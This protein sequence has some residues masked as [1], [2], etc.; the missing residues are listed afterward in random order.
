MQW[1]ERC[2]C[3]CVWL[4]CSMLLLI[5]QL[6]QN[7]N[8]FVTCSN[9]WRQNTTLLIFPVREIRCYPSIEC[10]TFDMLSR[11]NI[12]EHQFTRIMLKTWKSE[13][14]SLILFYNSIGLLHAF[15]GAFAVWGYSSSGLRMHRLPRA[16]LWLRTQRPLGFETWEFPGDVFCGKN[17]LPG[18]D[19]LQMTP[20]LWGF[21]I[22]MNFVNLLVEMSGK[23]GVTQR[24]RIWVVCW[25][26][27]WYSTSPCLFLSELKG[28]SHSWIVPWYHKTPIQAKK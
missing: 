14:A 24:C 26:T 12:I 22:F 23:R 17:H 28:F 15:T 19:I 27:H 21:M 16:C 2:L 5:C 6:K 18:N 10:M 25:K 8:K 20:F 3:V 1:K 4:F 13:L 7:V 9:L 11:L